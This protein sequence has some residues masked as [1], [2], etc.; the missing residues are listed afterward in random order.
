[1][2]CGIQPQ[3]SA[4]GWRGQQCRARHR[5][6]NRGGVGEKVEVRGLEEKAA[7]LRANGLEA[8]SILHK[9]HI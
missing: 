6:L 9:Q 4:V 2:C 7:S 3:T 1:V 5:R 8:E